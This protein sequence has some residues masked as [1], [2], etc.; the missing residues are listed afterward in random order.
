[1]EWTNYDFDQETFEL[2]R[3]EAG[4]KGRN[5]LKCLKDLENH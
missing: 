4:H 3:P 1:M 2:R 5:C